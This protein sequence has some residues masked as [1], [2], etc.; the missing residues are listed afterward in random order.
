MIKTRIA[1]SPTGNLHVGTARTALF[2]Y[3]FAR[4]YGGEFLLRIED[5]DIERS[6]KKF[7][8]DIIEGLRWLGIL[9]DGSTT[10]QTEHLDVYTEALTKLLNQK[11]AF[12]CP[13]TQKELEEERVTQHAQKQVPRHVCQNRDRGAK[14][15]IIRF[16]ND[17]TEPISFKDEI[18]GT[19]TSDP[20]LLGDFALAKD[21][22]TPLYN[23]AVVVDDAAFHISHVIRGEDHIPNTPK[24]ILIQEALG[25]PR[26][27]YAHLP[28]ILGSDRSKL[29]KRH[30][31]TSIREYRD[32]GYLADALFNFLA[33]LGWNSG[34]EKEIFSRAEL[35]ELFSLD[36]VQKSGA[37]FDI[38]KLNWMNN[39][40]I[41]TASLDVLQELAW[42]FLEPMMKQ[43][44]AE[45]SE[46]TIK[47]VIVLEQPRITKLSELPEQ[48]EYFFKDPAYEKELLRW[49]SMSDEE[50]KNA[51]TN[52]K[53][54]I[55]NIP[56]EHWN[57]KYIESML[58]KEAEAYPN[59][60]ELLWP[61]RVALSGKKAS[62]GPFEIMAI[63][64]KQRVLDRIQ[65]A[66]NI[67][68]A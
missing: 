62:P 31:A 14:E 5:T 65:N 55:E 10:H 49:K 56:E 50:L 20:Q 68:R 45:P 41:Q 36:R 26:P 58:L 6:K 61:L 33:L 60:G 27:V 54:I 39:Q 59:R 38:T 2:N 13:H 9:W 24:Q 17:I 4:R 66:L 64:G 12:F 35:I 29:S 16:K 48:V 67:L 15:G 22:R 44:A 34:T 21:L 51:F 40:Y 11:S 23:F 7:E 42:P 53:K 46:Q 63:L 47:Q 1:P 19:I 3:L 43:I 32:D 37:I 25:Y 52:A 30:S 18:R 28:L 57:I 8:E